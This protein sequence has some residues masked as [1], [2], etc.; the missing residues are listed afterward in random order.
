MKLRDTKIP[1]HITT[2]TSS[3]DSTCQI[4]TEQTQGLLTALYDT[5][6]QY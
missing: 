1:K 3:L 4:H 2:P 5:Q 6:L